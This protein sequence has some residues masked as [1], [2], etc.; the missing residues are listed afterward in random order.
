MHHHDH[1]HHHHQLFNTSSGPEQLLS[2]PLNTLFGSYGLAP[3]I[4][5]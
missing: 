2:G 3:E 1:H 4:N 5:A